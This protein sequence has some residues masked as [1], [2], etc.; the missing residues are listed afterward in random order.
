MLLQKSKFDSGDIVS[1]KLTSGEEIVGKFV[2]E[3]MME[4]VLTKVVMLAMTQKGVG[5][6]P[7]MVT[8]DPDKEYAINKQAII[9]KAPTDKEIADQY[10]Y[11]TT[12][13][14]PVSAGSIIK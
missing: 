6:A 13:I 5:M 1:L 12:G 9:M 14:Q 2:S 10:I 8:V 11:Q 3:D 7:Y 4:F